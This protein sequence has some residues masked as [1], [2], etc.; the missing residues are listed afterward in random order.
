MH[1]YEYADWRYIRNQFSSNRF[2]VALDGNQ[3]LIKLKDSLSAGKTTQNLSKMEIQIYLNQF[4]YHF[5][6]PIIT[7][8]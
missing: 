1:V 4:Y 5:I 8:T 3:R 7:Y 6:I 2:V